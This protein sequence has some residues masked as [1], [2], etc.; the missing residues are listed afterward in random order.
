LIKINRIGWL[1]RVKVKSIKKRIKILKI[2]K[3]ELN[4]YREKFNYN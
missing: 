3:K 4:H 2:F 1:Y